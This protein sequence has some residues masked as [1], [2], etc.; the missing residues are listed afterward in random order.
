MERKL[1]MTFKDELDASF[2]LIVNSVK[3]NVSQE[4]VNAI[5]DSV[6]STGAFESKNGSLVQKVSAKIVDTTE[7]EMEV[8]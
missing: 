2:N 7:T 3:D 8:Q 5:M 4:E 6:L 1:V